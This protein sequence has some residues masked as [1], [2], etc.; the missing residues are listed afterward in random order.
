ML[1]TLYIFT[2]Y[3]HQQTSTTQLRPALDRLAWLRRRYHAWNIWST[4]DQAS[5]RGEGVL[6]SQWFGILWD[7]QKN[8]IAFSGNS[9]WIP[10]HRTT[11]HQGHHHLLMREFGEN[12]IPTCTGR[13]A[14]SP[15]C[16][17]GIGEH[18]A[19]SSKLSPLSHRTCKPLPCWSLHGIRLVYHV[20]RLN[21]KFERLPFTIRGL[22]HLAPESFR[23]TS[24]QVPNDGGIFPPWHEAGDFSLM[25]RKIRQI[26]QRSGANTQCQHWFTLLFVFLVFTT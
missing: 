13:G 20:C 21:V 17:R 22:S 1:S 9:P 18:L 16:T 7:A 8:C 24:Q 3:F 6:G 5:L 10:N 12:R 23:K 19:D 4:W 26:S 11:N 14:I 2:I 25:R 15:T